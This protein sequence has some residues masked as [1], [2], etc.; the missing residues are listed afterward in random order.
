MGFVGE[1]GQTVP[2]QI[3]VE[4]PTTL[5]GRR[6]GVFI[7]FRAGQALLEPQVAYVLP[8]GADIVLGLEVLGI[9]A[10]HEGLTGVAFG[11]PVYRADV[12]EKDVLLPEHDAW[13]GLGQEVLSGVRAESDDD[14]VPSLP[15]PHRAQHLAGH[16]HG[17]LLDH[18]RLDVRRD[19]PKGVVGAGPDVELLLDG[20]VR[21]G[22]FDI[23]TGAHSALSSLPPTVQAGGRGRRKPRRMLPLRQHKLS[24][25]YVADIGPARVY[26]ADTDLR[27]GQRSRTRQAVRDR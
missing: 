22:R 17:V 9:L 15:H 2:G 4:P 16:R 20:E 7:Q 24:D 18:A 25:I 11:V 23:D 13:L 12:D 3:E 6:A 10:E 1:L 21:S 19:L 5:D 27:L 26:V 14:P 8:Q